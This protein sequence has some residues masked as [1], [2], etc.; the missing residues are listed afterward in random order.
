MRIRSIFQLRKWVRLFVNN[1]VVREKLP[2]IVYLK[3][4]YYAKLGKKLHLNEPVTYNEKIQWL[5]LYDRQPYY[6]RMVDKYEAKGYIAELIGDQYVIPSIGVWDN[7]DDI[8]FDKLPERFVL[9]CTHDSGGVVICKDKRY[10]DMEAAKTKINASIKRNYF[11]SG[12]EW[13]YKYIKPRVIAEEYLEDAKYGELRDYK[14]FAFD[15]IPRLMFVASERQSKDE[16]K[17][18]FFDMDFHF[19]DMRNGHPNAEKRPECPQ[20]FELMKELTKKLSKG[21]PHVRVDFYEVNGRVYVGELTLYHWSGMTPF[22]PPEWDNR[23]GS[24]IRLPSVKTVD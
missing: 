1:K 18:D 10:F 20:Y 15:G 12:R 5:K 6:V 22:D 9:K 4:C 13:P 14:F 17:F 2:D 19:V 23:M 11:Y 16:T 8:E 24:W 3:L 21:L 7:F